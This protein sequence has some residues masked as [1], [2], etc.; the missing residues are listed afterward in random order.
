MKIKVS[1]LFFILSLSTKI[2]AQ[3]LVY[4]GDF[5]IRDT[6]PDN[7]GQITRAIGWMV[8]G[9][10]PDY[11][12]SCNNLNFNVPYAHMGYQ[13]DCCG[14]G[15]IAGEYMMVSINVLGD[16]IGREYMET[17]LI[18]TLVAGHK[19]IASIY[20]NR[21]N[22]NY[23]LATIGM[24]FTDTSIVLPNPS[25]GNLIYANPQIKNV[26]ILTDTAQW[27]IV[28]DTFIAIGTEAYLTIGNFN[29]TAT[30][31]TL[32][33]PASPWLGAGSAYY[34]ID[35]VSVYDVTSGACNNY[36][37][38][39]FDKYILMGDSIRIGAINTDNSTYSWVNS[40]GGTT[41]LNNNADARPWSTP[42][43]TTTYYVT[44]TCPNGNTFMDTVTVY[45]TDTNSMKITQIKNIGRI[46]IYPNPTSDKIYSSIKE[47]ELK[48]FD[49]IGNEILSTKEKE[50]DVSKLEAGIYFIE[51]ETTLGISTQKIVIQH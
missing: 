25:Q 44:K 7:M 11:N 45:V 22:F 28:Q 37:D 1:I 38:A 4:N 30:S 20:V 14:G 13:Q 51:A 16:D 50:M 2:Q 33:E 29:T 40:A 24:L 18:D 47:G 19:Y 3:N 5:E 48:L 42:S 49:M 15:G 41:Y 6:C 21:A 10:S 23:S 35:G 17:K 26:A 8:A 27:V 46:K 43:V 39:G 32:S 9:G 31:D 34:Y 36:W 12:N